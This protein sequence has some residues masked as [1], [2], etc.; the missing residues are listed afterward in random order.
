MRVPHLMFVAL[1]VTSASPVLA[2]SE[3]SSYYLVQDRTTNTCKVVDVKP[4]P[5]GVRSIVYES[6]EM[7]EAAIAEASAYDFFD[8]S[9]TGPSADKVTTGSTTTVVHK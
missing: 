6:R 8:C 2:G 5:D 1:V 9:V 4:T 3:L 7:A